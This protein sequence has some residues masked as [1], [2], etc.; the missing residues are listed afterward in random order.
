MLPL[1]TEKPLKFIGRVST[2]G[3]RKVVIYIPQQHHEEALKRF[4]GKA[5]KVTLE[6]IAL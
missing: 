1:L 5:L 3:A 6:E 4:K 2:M